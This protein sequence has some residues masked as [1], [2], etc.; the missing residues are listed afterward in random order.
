[1]LSRVAERIYWQSRYIERAESTARL[2][3]EYSTLLLDMPQHTNLGWHT[4]VEITGTHKQFNASGRQAMERNIMRFL[5]VEENGVSLLSML[6]MTRESA[7]TTREIMPR[8]AFEQINNLYHYAEDELG[9]AV[10]RGPRHER[11]AEII[12]GCQRLTGLLAGS[13]SHNDVYRFVRMGRNLERA[14]M[15]TRIVDVGSGNLL[16][17]KRRQQKQKQ[18]QQRDKLK[19]TPASGTE[20][21]ENILWMSVLHSTSGYQMYRQYVK[22]RVNAEDVVIFLLQDPEFPRSLAHTIVKMEQMMERL[23]K[24]EQALVQVRKILRLLKQA[25]IET[26]LHGDGLFQFIDELQVQIG[27]LHERIAA[28]WFLPIK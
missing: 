19:D 21:F 2:L 4:L 28:T 20:P 7:R 6:A 5:L 9:K 23:S 25:K 13:M 1:M 16:G 17:G 3:G 8:E 18:Q 27:V 10:T 14:D 15:T 12:S 24:S 22:D 11:L 26:L